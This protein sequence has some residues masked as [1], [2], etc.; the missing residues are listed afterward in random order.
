[1]RCRCVGIASSVKSPMAR[2]TAALLLVACAPTPTGGWASYL[3]P[4]AANRLHAA[5]R[6]APHVRAMF[7]GIIEEMGV[8]RRLEK[9]ERMEMWDGSVGEGWELEVEGSEVLDG[10]TLGC[11]IAVNGVCLTVTEFDA[12]TASFGLAPETLRRSNLVSLTKGDPVNLER[13]L[14][15]DGRNSGHFVQGHVDD[16]GI[17]TELRPDGDSLY[18]TIKPPARLLPYIVPKGFICVDG[19]SLTVCDVDAAAGTFNF[20][21]IAFTQQK[22]IIPKKAIGDAVN[23]EVDVIS[24]YVEQSLAAV[25]ARVEALEKRLEAVGSS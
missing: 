12:S 2:W 9:V 22:V 17:I 1:M 24:K 13:A 20:M 15:A 19:T 6:R 14:A 5:A 25:V 23:L 18:V 8:V 16:V 11:S 10:A 4:P 7:S 21:L 3:V